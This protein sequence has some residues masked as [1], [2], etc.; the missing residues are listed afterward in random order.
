MKNYINSDKLSLNKYS[1]GYSREYPNLNYEDATKHRYSIRRKSPEGAYWWHGFDQADSMVNF[2]SS[3]IGDG[4]ETHEI[5]GNCSE[6]IKHLLFFDIDAGAELFENIKLTFDMLLELLDIKVRLT[7]AMGTARPIVLKC[8]R[9]GKYSAH[10]IYPVLI[11]SAHAKCI[12]LHVA[13]GMRRLLTEIGYNGDLAN[14]IDM[15]VYRSVSSMRVMGSP[16]YSYGSRVPGFVNEGGGDVFNPSSL[17]TVYDPSTPFKSCETS[18]CNVKAHGK[19][20]K[21]TFVGDETSLCAQ[22]TKMFPQYQILGIANNIIKIK[23]D[24]TANCIICGRKHS[25]ENPYAIINNDGS[26][27]LVC[28]RNEKSRLV[29]IEAPKETA[30]KEQ[31]AKHDK[32][33][34]KRILI[35]QMIF[36]M[37]MKK[38][39]GRANKT[40]VSQYM[41]VLHPVMKEHKHLAL[42]SPLGSG[43]TKALFDFIETYG[44]YG[45]IIS[46]IHRKSLTSNM[47]PR[48]KK[49]GFVI[50]D[51]VDGEIDVKKHKRI[52]IQYESLHRLNLMGVRLDLLICDEVN[53]ICMQYLSKIGKHNRGISE[54]ILESLFRS[55]RNS[56]MMDG[57]LCDR[58][59]NGINC[60]GQREYYVWNNNSVNKL[61]PNILLTE[62]NASFNLSL[63]K[64]LKE[65]F[66]CELVTSR[67]PDYCETMA[68]LLRKEIPGIKLLVLHSE[69]E[70]RDQYTADVEN[71]WIKYDCIIRSP[72][73]GAGI[74]FTAAHFDYCFVDVC[75][76]GPL[77]DD[78][79]QAMRRSRHIKSNTYVVH[80]G[81]CATTN[82]PTTYDGVLRQV[83]G[84]VSHNLSDSIRPDFDGVI[85]DG[86]FRFRDLENPLLKFDIWCRA[87]RN[88]QQNN[89]VKRLMESFIRM[90]ATFSFIDDVSKEEKTLLD[91]RVADISDAIK[92]LNF[93][94]TAS[95]EEITHDKFEELIVKNRM[96]KDERSTVNKY[97][98]RTNYKYAGEM[99]EEW[100]KKYS[101]AS[102]L[103]MNKHI[104]SRNTAINELAAVSDDMIENMTDVE[105]MTK[106][107]TSFMYNVARTKIRDLY[108]KHNKTIDLPVKLMEYVNN[109]IKINNP[110][111]GS[112]ELK[113]S[114][115]KF[116]L[117]AVNA[118]LNVLGY[119]IRIL[120]LHKKT[121]E[122]KNIYEFEWFDIAPNYYNLPETIEKDPL[123]PDFP[124]MK[125]PNQAKYA[126]LL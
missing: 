69:T 15:N 27:S 101:D 43:K 95:A 70:N 54:C 117:V 116:V 76:G 10:V 60:L 42:A 37:K 11:S 40:T 82:H 52:L 32:R 99:N 114:N 18:F 107:K 125:P 103:S 84:A 57:N 90:G 17:I 14:C 19:T 35:D 47:R 62:H 71:E 49:A 115:T 109:Q 81:K 67:G 48:Y 88:K 51:E 72:A 38:L 20:E 112:K 119:E 94:C 92:S 45:I 9:P 59:V 113:T 79:L 46:V 56:I 3:H 120:K 96:S 126:E 50:Y 123:K 24:H 31:P 68:E 77:A 80:F 108:D 7:V 26:V 8:N 111:F 22:I 36:A 118:V 12:P 110:I 13:A 34:P 73:I 29:I 89:I 23:D 86:R 105:R 87:Y 28:R 39:L 83:E 124:K 122:N 44:K 25:N 5:I 53:S 61:S 93:K 1:C 33:T 63:I 21:R 16:K 4:N 41:E 2:I 97:L 55:A 78:V 106:R 64:K 66:K 100:V 104:E 65:L 91:G 30:N 75:S 85:R 6:D 58:I 98:L 121:L 102:I 74:D